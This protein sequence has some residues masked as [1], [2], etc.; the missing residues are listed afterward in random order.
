MEISGGTKL[1]Y[2]KERTL[3]GVRDDPIKGDLVGRF[4][5]WLVCLL[6]VVMPAQDLIYLQLAIREN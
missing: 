4:V 1:V 6:K 5:Q 2:G 3:K